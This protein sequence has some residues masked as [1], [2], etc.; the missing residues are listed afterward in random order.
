VSQADSIAGSALLWGSVLIAAIIV[1]GAIIWLVRRWAF[2]PPTMGDA[3]WSLQHL[4]EMK[5]QGRITADEF[6]ALRLRALRAS[7]SQASQKD[8]ATSAGGRG[9]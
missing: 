9:R 1:L 5:A 3:F 4:R 2:K 7:Q 8:G 6:E